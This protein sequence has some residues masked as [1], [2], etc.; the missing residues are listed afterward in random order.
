MSRTA[1]TEPQC[2]YKGD[3]YIFT[4]CTLDVSNQLLT[5]NRSI[6]WSFRLTRG[7]VYGKACWLTWLHNQET[8]GLKE[9]RIV[10]MLSVTEL[11]V[12]NVA[13]RI[14]IPFY[15][16]KTATKTLPPSRLFIPRNRWISLAEL[17]S[18]W[19]PSLRCTSSYDRDPS[20]G[21]NRIRQAPDCCLLQWVGL[22]STS[23]ALRNKRNQDF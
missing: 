20:K 21:G 9:R 5:S 10:C 4:L 11:L 2:L 18:F 7:N 6:T 13:T 16:F 3:L 23:S 17:W 14:L 19:E 15:K 12:S 8:S 1:C 22:R